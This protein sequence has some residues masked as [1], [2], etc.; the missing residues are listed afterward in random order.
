[1]SGKKDT[2]VDF[3]PQE[4][5]EDQGRIMKW[6]ELEQGGENIYHVMRY[7]ENTKSEFETRNI[8][9]EMKKQDSPSLK[10]Y[11]CGHIA[12]NI[13][14]KWKLMNEGQNL[15]IRPNGTAKS[16]AGYTYN[17]AQIDIR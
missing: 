8:I 1:M 9:L 13:C 17:V 2:A 11:C 4:A 6:S 12:E 7:V 14:S 15:F 3:P 5:F 16:K 10:V